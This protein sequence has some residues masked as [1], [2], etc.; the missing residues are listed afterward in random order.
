MEGYTLKIGDL[1]R[2]P[3]RRV[4]CGLGQTELDLAAHPSSYAAANVLRNLTGMVAWLPTKTSARWHPPQA[5]GGGVIGASSASIAVDAAISAE[6]VSPVPLRAAH[7]NAAGHAVNPF[8][9]T[10]FPTLGACAAPLTEVLGPG[11][12]TFCTERPL[13][14]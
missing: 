6:P 14:V 5:M 11:P 7:N 12:P 9:S 3:P 4:T 8:L 2:P 1:G 13:I 10:S